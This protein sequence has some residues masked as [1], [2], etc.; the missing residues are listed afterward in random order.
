MPRLITLTTDFGVR[1][2]YA[3]AM[4]G[5][6]A[7][8][9]PSATILDLTHE[10]AAHD[11]FEAAVFLAGAT[12]YFP[13]ET[14]HVV[15]VDPGVGTA[16]RPVAV[17]AGGATYVC[18]DNGVLTLALR[19]M[20]LE[21]AR[22][23]RS[24]AFRRE[25]VSA[26]FHGRDVFAPAAAA[27]AAGASF[28]AIGPR[29]AALTELDAPRVTR[30]VERIAGA[31][32]HVDRFGNGITNVHREDVGAAA[33]REVVI[34]GRTLPMERTYGDVAPGGALALWGSSDL[35]EVAVHRGRAD[36]ALGAT[37]G[38][39]VEVWIG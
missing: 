24:A 38:A 32:V 18:P 20:P 21:E 17:R 28:S 34:G 5:V 36:V 9:A 23:I 2:C 35:L 15:V 25:C 22:E 14:I 7:T 19:R 3:A 39:P 10:I 29:M 27:L 33:V 6:I 31:V 16:R 13:P 11:V 12:P 37:R 30:D 26:T 1:D 4:K 8:L